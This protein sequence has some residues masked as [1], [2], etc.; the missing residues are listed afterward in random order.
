MT[1]EPLPP[2]AGGISRPARFAKALLVLALP[3]LYCYATP[4][5]VA[6]PPPAKAEAPPPESPKDPLGRITPRGTVI[7]FLKAARSGNAEVAALYLN[8]HLREEAAQKLARELAMVLDTRLPARLS[9]ISDLPEGSLRDPLNPDQDLVGTITTA[10]GDLDI[11]V[12]RVDR[13]KF[14]KMWVF[15]N[16]TLASIPGVY[17]ELNESPIEKYLPQFL[18][19]TKLATIPLFEWLAVFVGLPGLYLF[20]WGLNR[21][22]SWVVSLLFRRFS[23]DVQIKRTH[24]LPQPIRLLLIATFIHWLLSKVP[25]PLLARQF[26]S[27]ASVLIAI[28]GCTWMLLLLT[29][30]SE[31]YLLERTQKLSGSAAVLRLVRRL[32]DLLVCFTGVLVILYYF[33]VNVTAAMAGLGVGGIAVALAAQKT[34]E[35]VIAGVSLIADKAV[36]VGDVLNLGDLAGTVK[37]VGLRST[38]IRTPDRTV[39]SVPNSQIANM[40][41]ETLSAR[42]KFWFHPTIGLLYETSNRQLRSILSEVRNLLDEHPSV[43]SASVRVRFIRIGAS[44][45]DMEIFSY[46]LALDW[47][48]FLEVQENLLFS[49]RDIVQQTG[50]SIAFPSQ[51]VYL[52]ED[53]TERTA[54]F[55]SGSRKRHPPADY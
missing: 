4:S 51:T 44:S 16:Q 45:L 21:V 18:L 38:R 20:M 8:T 28:A 1:P 27:A 14:G 32:V 34:L 9:Q 35:N 54:R 26:W 5:Q 6:A 2:R 37:D 15:S 43:D 30:W 29:R 33:H 31:H 48:S 11:M 47:D 52:S 40:R 49:I 7:G 55:E 13:G 41:L 10:K 39:V 46:V 25:L 17:E 23:G 53:T 42:D 12:D 22:L 36:R 50:T 19:T 3:F 24:I